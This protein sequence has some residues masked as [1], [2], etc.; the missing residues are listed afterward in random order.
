MSR[1]FET[2]L[3]NLSPKSDILSQEKS[4]H[5]VSGITES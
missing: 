3:K 1:D 2:S 4:G 5:S